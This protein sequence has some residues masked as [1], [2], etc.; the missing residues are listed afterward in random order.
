MINSTSRLIVLSL[1]I[2]SLAAPA[3]ASAEPVEWRPPVSLD[4][5]DSLRFQA[6]RGIECP[7]DSFCAAVDY[8]GDLLL[9]ANPGGGTGAWQSYAI[10]AEPEE[11][12]ED[13]SCPS[14]SF[15]AAISKQGGVFTSTD[16]SAGSA[17]WHRALIPGAAEMTTISCAGPSLCV[18][19]NELGHLF[20]SSEPTAGASSWSERVIPGA[21]KFQAVSCP[22]ATFCAAVDAGDHDEARGWESEIY[23]ATDPTGS[24]SAWEPAEVLA[25]DGIAVDI[26]CPSASFCLS[27]FKEGVL[28]SDDPTAGAAAWEYTDLGD[29]PNRVSCPSSG[30]CAGYDTGMDLTWTSEEPLGGA[31]GWDDSDT[32]GLEL[33][34]RGI[35]CSSASF[36]AVLAWVGDIATTEDPAGGP[37]AW[38]VATTGGFDGVFSGVSC[39]EAGFCAAVDYNGNVYT[40]EEPLEGSS[41]SG[42]QVTSRYTGSISCA[43]SNF[44]AFLGGGGR[45]LFS[46]D[47]GGGPGAWEELSLP[48]P[49]VEL[50]CPTADFCAAV[51]G[52]EILTST[53]PTVAG[54]WAITDLE[55]P[56]EYLGPS[57]LEQISCPSPSFCAVAGTTSRVLASDDPTGGKATWIPGFVGHPYPEGNPN[58]TPPTGDLSCR[59]E[60]FCSVI[61]AWTVSSTTNPLGGS[62]AWQHFDVTGGRQPSGLS[63]P[64]PSFCLSTDGHEAL[65]SPGVPGPGE[66]WG[67]PQMLDGGGTLGPVSCDPSLAVCVAVDDSGQV[68]RGVPNPDGFGVEEA[69]D[70]CGG[71]CPVAMSSGDRPPTRPRRCKAKKAKG[72]R[73]GRIAIGAAIRLS[74]VP[75]GGQRGPRPCG[76]R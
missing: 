42:Q 63:C 11:I 34:A 19:G 74:R 43:S 73:A 48:K 55:L 28:G 15:C 27:A 58:Y 33:D 56:D 76:S 65:P 70:V 71:P 67:Q 66:E 30:F 10:G 8:V 47:P 51:S 21:V 72:A 75:R 14:A 9:S 1:A 5:Q 64:D 38:D 50:S 3:A 52:D 32:S 46:T 35:S 7:S 31:A 45:F 60:E 39:P 62:D 57:R 25:Q 13:L 36:C 40:S 61:W 37:A 4:D 2:F 24:A 18:A 22:S 20:V 59:S 41:W 68:F 29:R 54:S 53:E 26:D 16:P 6:G 12:V 44:C 69:A 17:S 23:V 49:A